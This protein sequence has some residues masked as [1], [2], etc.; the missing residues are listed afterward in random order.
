MTNS[1]KL[2][3]VA[4]L[5]AVI[6]LGVVVFRP[7]TPSLGGVTEYQKKSFVEGFFAG[8]GREVEVTRSGDLT[9][10]GGTLNVTTA[11][12]ATSTII[13]GC[14]QFYSTST[15]TALKFQASTTPGAMY[16]Q[17]GSCPNL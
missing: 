4:I 16:S 8:T 3:I 5:I 11:N 17:Y 7:A 9:I 6:A 2:G 14:F 10:G 13:G 12:T 1:N 15:A